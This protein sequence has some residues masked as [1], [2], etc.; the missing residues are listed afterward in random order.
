M[1]P[2]PVPV[3]AEGSSGSKGFGDVVGIEDGDCV[4]PPVQLGEGDPVEFKSQLCGKGDNQSGEISRRLHRLFHQQKRLYR[5]QNLV[6]HPP[7]SQSH[8]VLEGRLR[9][10]FQNLIF[11]LLI[12]YLIPTIFYITM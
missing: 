4:H 7:I 9:I 12:F 3:P 10:T 2:Q 11:H 1:F 6:R 5:R 8:N